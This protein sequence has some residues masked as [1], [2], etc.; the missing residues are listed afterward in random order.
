M[1]LERLGKSLNHYVPQKR[2]APAGVSREVIGPHHIKL[3]ATKFAHHYAFAQ[4]FTQTLLVVAGDVLAGLTY[5]HNN[6]IAHADLKEEN[7]CL[8]ELPWPLPSTCFG[9]TR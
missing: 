3:F 2:P 5:L 9:H 7:I 1:L 6:N 8:C 4:P